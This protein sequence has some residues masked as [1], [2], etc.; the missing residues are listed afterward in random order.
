MTLDCPYRMTRKIW[1]PSFQSLPPA[2]HV[3]MPASRAFVHT[4]DAATLRTGLSAALVRLW[5]K[6]PQLPLLHVRCTTER[7]LALLGRDV[8]PAPCWKALVAEV[9]VGAGHRGRQR[10]WPHVRLV[11]GATKAPATTITTDE[12]HDDRPADAATHI[13]LCAPGANDAGETG[14]DS[15][16]RWLWVSPAP[17]RTH[18]DEEAVWAALQGSGTSA[19]TVSPRTLPALVR[20]KRPTAATV[21]RLPVLTAANRASHPTWHAYY[22]RVYHVPVPPGAAVDLNAFTWFYDC[23][24]F[25][26]PVRPRRRLTAPAI[27]AR[28]RCPAAATHG[29]DNDDA[30]VYIPDD[31]LRDPT[32]HVPAT[33][34]DALR[35]RPDEAY[36]GMHQTVT[37]LNRQLEARLCLFGFFVRRAPASR[38]PAGRVL[39][40][41]TEVLHVAD[42][43]G[44]MSARDRR[45]I[46]WY[47]C[48]RGS[49]VWV[50]P[51]AL[52]VHAS[53]CRVYA[54]RRSMP[55][56][57]G[58]CATNTI[59]AVDHHGLV[60]TMVSQ[61][62]HAVVFVDAYGCPEL[63][64][65]HPRLRPTAVCTVA[66]STTGFLT[67]GDATPQPC[68]CRDDRPVLQCAHD[69]DRT[70]R[71][72]W[73][74]PVQHAVIEAVQ[75]RDP[76][77]LMATVEAHGRLAV[78]L[79]LNTW[80]PAELRLPRRGTVWA[81][82]TPLAMA[83]LCGHT[84]VVR[85]CVSLGASW[86]SRCPAHRRG[87]DDPPGLDARS[88][89]ATVMGRD[90]GE[91]KK[92]R[93]PS[94][95]Q[96]RRRRSRRRHRRSRR[97]RSRSA[98]RNRS[99][100]GRYPR[101]RHHTRRPPA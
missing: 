21:P 99:P 58:L 88:W 77:P 60:P 67:T 87:A 19:R 49:G 96:E 29:S 20:R 63:V 80:L 43:A 5:F 66:A 81:F 45:P 9:E 6:N 75:A 91:K 26:P 92:T 84:V 3:T 54:H 17:G 13:G 41:R 73:Y 24:P 4:V 64:L 32:L 39:A 14:G 8:V 23:A 51:S 83:A 27:L 82:T 42:A 90:G 86:T 100:S 94:G 85:V 65:Q 52:G 56:Y 44:E 95:R 28:L 34:R 101:P 1:P 33:A 79:A 74:T 18:V 12:A 16:R 31:D 11:V 50:D 69:A 2:S 62:L 78:R 37:K 30:A 38:P 47:W 35:L 36:V 89:L 55:L 72:L 76:A 93:A 48:V 46:A 68:V 57:R 22:E 59:H 15:K 40:G 61:S 10:A 7:Q 70:A 97:R 25:D 53:Q 71:P 98:R